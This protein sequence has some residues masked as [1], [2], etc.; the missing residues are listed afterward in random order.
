M[1]DDCKGSLVEDVEDGSRPDGFS[2]SDGIFVDGS[3]NHRYFPDEQV[4]VGVVLAPV[5]HC[6]DRRL[7]RCRM[8]GARMRDSRNTTRGTRAVLLTM[9]GSVPIKSMPTKSMRR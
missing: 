8:G 2:F 5:I 7:R 4:L 3:L 6:E 9:T 1:A